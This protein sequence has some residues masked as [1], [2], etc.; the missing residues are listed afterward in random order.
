[1]LFVFILGYL[2]AAE[3]HREMRGHDI[4][5]RGIVLTAVAIDEL[6][7]GLR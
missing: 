7:V 5:K 6:L 1:V 3:Q 4:S 2:I